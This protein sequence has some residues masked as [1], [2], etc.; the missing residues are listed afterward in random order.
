MENLKNYLTSNQATSL[1]WQVANLVVL[2]LIG[3]VTETGFYPAL[4]LPI[5]NS[6]T[7]LINTTYLQK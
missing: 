4:L 5:L 6:L 7:K 3:I 2:L 1:Y